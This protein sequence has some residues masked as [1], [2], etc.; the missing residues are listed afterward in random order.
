M[1]EN[2]TIFLNS[3]INR[4]IANIYST[5]IKRF[6]DFTIAQIVTQIVAYIDNNYIFLEVFA[7]KII[8]LLSSLTNIFIH[9][10]L[11]IEIWETS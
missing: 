10:T 3:P 4:S 6:L 8:P 9:F 11:N 1:I 7:L 5:I 2:F